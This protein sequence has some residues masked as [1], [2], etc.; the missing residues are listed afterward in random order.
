MGR[1]RLI[2]L[3]LILGACVLPGC[4]MHSVTLPS[5][6]TAVHHKPIVLD[7]NLDDWQG[8]AFTQVT[9]DNGIFDEES[10]GQGSWRDA[11]DADDL[12]FRF[13]VCHDDEA[14]YIAVE[15]TDD[16]L[17]T[18]DTSSKQRTATAWKDDAVEIFIDGNHN[19][20]PNA[21]DPDG[22]EYQSGG[23]FA[24][25]FNG[26]TTSQC[27]GFAQTFGDA[28]YW[29]GATNIN[30]VRESKV[31]KHIYEFRFAWSVMGGKVRPGDT[32][33]LTLGVMD[34]DDGLER[35]HAL[36][37]KAISPCC[38]RDESGW[39]TVFIKPFSGD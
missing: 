15:V 14:L 32:I 29:Q 7:G 5:R 24:L 18:D 21:R 27:S 26:A 33:G 35:D 31:T 10:Y 30:A 9:P 12:S 17:V 19:R 11:D 25:V 22:K 34:D 2:T 37:W 16:H 20:A 36:F 23:E 3:T 13:A 4:S 38:W 28:V 8:I 1:N 39:G 6:I